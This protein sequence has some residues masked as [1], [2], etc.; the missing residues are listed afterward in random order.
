MGPISSGSKPWK[1]ISKGERFETLKAQI[2]LTG[3]SPRELSASS[4][5]DGLSG[6][7]SGSKPIAAK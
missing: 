4:G 2:E 3:N 7:G 1:C 6:R 5:S